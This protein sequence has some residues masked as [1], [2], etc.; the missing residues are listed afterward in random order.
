MPTNVPVNKVEC[1]VLVIGG[2]PAGSSAARASALH[3]KKTILIDKRSEIGYPVHC[4]EGMGNY[5][6]PFLPLEIPREQLIWPTEGIEFW[7]ED[8]TIRRRGVMWSGYTVNR[9]VFDKWLARQATASG[10]RLHLKAELVD[11][12]LGERHVVKKA[13]IKTGD[14]T[15]EVKPKVVIG[16]DGYDSTTLRLLGQY[17]PTEGAVAQI[18]AWEMKHV[19]LA[20]PKYEQVFVGDFTDTGYAYVFPISRTRANIGVGCAYPKKSM[21]D[22]FQEFLE[23]PEMRHQTR[24]AVKVEDK[25]GPVNALPLAKKWNFGNV[26]LA[27]DAADQN[28]K[29]FVEGILPAIICG[30]IAGNHAVRY[31]NGQT[32]LQEYEHD[33]K[34]T[35][36]PIFAQSDDVGKLIYELFGMNQPKKYLL[37]MN[38]LADL[39]S[40]KKVHQ[41]KGQ[42]YDEIRDKTLLWQEHQKQIPTR[43]MEYLWYQYVKADRMIQKIVP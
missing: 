28:I 22:Y 25:G 19:N 35:M 41:M 23:I 33:I 39:N 43:I 24:A 10:A 3:G 4:A 14:G 16:A 8:V 2:G 37:L 26:I 31:L 5:L 38:L 13:I 1:D 36:G 12:E 32:T 17:R 21:E 11:V 29:P 9:R 15:M 30:D 18:Y 7:A 6:L 42:T 34:K 40:P 20:S 27:G